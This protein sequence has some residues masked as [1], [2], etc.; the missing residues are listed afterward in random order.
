MRTLRFVAFRV[1]IVAPLYTAWVAAL[2]ALPLSR[3]PLQTA[4]IRSALDNIIF[5]PPLH[6]A[7]FTTM[8]WWEGSDAEEALYR[9][10]MM[11]PRSLPASWTFWVP[12]QILTYGLVPAHMRV[13]FVQATS[14][15][16]NSIMSGFNE[17]ARR[18]GA[19]APALAS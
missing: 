4:I 18:H 5:S 14:L 10:V 15:A 16:W 12:T 11:L 6:V 17:L 1:A 8:A 2:S 3:P 7:F 19:C 9:S 13:A